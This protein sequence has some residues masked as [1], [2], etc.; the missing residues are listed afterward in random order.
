MVSLFILSLFWR[1]I[2]YIGSNDDMVVLIEELMMEIIYSR[3]IVVELVL[4]VVGC[5]YYMVV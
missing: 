3:I 5:V 4:I 1:C 2:V